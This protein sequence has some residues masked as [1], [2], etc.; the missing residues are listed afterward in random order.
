MRTSIFALVATSVLLLAC[1]DESSTSSTP[2]NTLSDRQ[3]LVMLAQGAGMTSEF[4]QISAGATPPATVA[5]RKLDMCSDK[6]GNHI[7]T[8][9]DDSTGEKMIMNLQVT[10]PGGAPLT[11][12]AMSAPNSN[13]QFSLSMNSP[14]MSMTMA[15]QGSRRDDGSFSASGNANGTFREDGMSMGFALQ[16]QQTVDAAGTITAYSGNISM[17]IDGASTDPLAF[18]LGG[19][20]PQT[21]KVYRG[22]N[23]IGT[24]TFAADGSAQIRDASG[25]L[26]EDDTLG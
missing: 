20:A 26:V 11:C 8:L 12:E 5:A 4:G 23:V 22:S 17:N 10:L 18:D 2:S 6:L 1:G 15:F 14:S 7:D 3:V 25:A 16:F 9:F 19:I 13:L 24:I 21:V